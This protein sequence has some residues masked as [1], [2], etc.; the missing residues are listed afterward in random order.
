MNFSEE[1][2]FVAYIGTD[3][4]SLSTGLAAFVM[5]TAVSNPAYKFHILTENEKVFQDYFDFN[6]IQNDVM[7]NVSFESISDYS[8]NM[9]AATGYDLFMV[10]GVDSFLAKKDRTSDYLAGL[11]G[12]N[13]QHQLIAASYET[14]PSG[15]VVPSG[16]LMSHVEKNHFSY[17][18]GNELLNFYIPNRV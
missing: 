14:F 15:L 7:P 9:A 13:G 6:G 2:R 11:F 16:T 5:M 17:M 8:A 18:E 4:R 1:P 10:D 12:G 3:R